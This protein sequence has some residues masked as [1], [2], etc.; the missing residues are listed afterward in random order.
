MSNGWSQ[1]TWGTSDFGWGGLLIVSVE[2]TS[3]SASGNVGSIGIKK[4]AVVTVSRE[5]TQGG[6]G[7]SS[8][9]GGAWNEATSLPDISMSGAVGSTFV[10]ADANV[11]GLS[12]VA[13]IKFLGDE[14]VITNNNISVTGFGLNNSLGAFS[15]ILVNRVSVTGIGASSNIN[16]VSTTGDAT[17]NVTGLSLVTSL[18]N[19]LVWGKINTTQIPNW[20]EIREAA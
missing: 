14:E 12:G 16:S 10:N 20:Q 17:V 15:I 5:A 11:T 4:S 7:R 2:V 3:V 6:W 19:N 9:G 18:G 8:W 13:G 1:N